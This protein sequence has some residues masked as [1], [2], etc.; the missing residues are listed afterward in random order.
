M[1]R[2]HPL[3]HLTHDM[4]HAFSFMTAVNRC[5]GATAMDFRVTCAPHVTSG[6]TPM[7]P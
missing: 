4:I 2:L 3:A 6:S 7:L 1:P 5:I